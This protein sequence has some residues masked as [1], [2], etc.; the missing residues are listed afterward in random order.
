MLGQHVLVIIN[1]SK[2]ALLMWFICVTRH[3]IGDASQHFLNLSKQFTTVRL[4]GTFHLW[5][6]KTR[7]KTNKTK[8]R[9]TLTNL[10]SS[11]PFYFSTAF[12]FFSSFPL[13]HCCTWV[14]LHLKKRPCCKLPCLLFDPSLT[15]EGKSLSTFQSFP[16]RVCQ[17]K[18]TVWCARIHL[19]LT[20]H[21]EISPWKV[22]KVGLL[23]NSALPWFPLIN[24]YV[25]IVN[26]LL[27]RLSWTVWFS[28]LA[29]TCIHV[30]L[31]NL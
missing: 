31:A 25:L 3:K 30:C 12:C 19:N 1:Q 14:L 29:C 20:L 4:F 8:W 16:T 23:L 26:W 24:C 21:Q 6:T 22:R 15:C 2:R 13:F 28:S 18:F 17:L 27:K 7:M 10:V 11:K 9:S 5:P